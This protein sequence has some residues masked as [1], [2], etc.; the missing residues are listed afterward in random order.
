MSCENDEL[1]V[2]DSID[3]IP[4]LKFS[5]IFD[6]KKGEHQQNHFGHRPWYEHHGIWRYSRE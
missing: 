1:G 2:S 4:V 5:V 3:L 6:Q